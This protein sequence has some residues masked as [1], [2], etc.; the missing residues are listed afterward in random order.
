M[1]L[2]KRTFQ[3]DPQTRPSNIG[4]P[5]TGHF[6]ITV[7]TPRG[8]QPFQPGPNAFVTNGKAHPS[9]D[10]KPVKQE[11]NLEV[12][13]N[14]YDDKGK[15][16]AVSGDGKERQANGGGREGEASENAKLESASQASKKTFRCFTCGIDCTKLRFHY[17]KSTPATANANPNAGAPDSK[18]DLC[19]TCFLQGRLPA[20]HQASDF[21]KLEDS[22]YTRFPDRDAPWTDSELLLLLEG[23]ENFDDDWGQIAQHVG[24]RTAEECVMK[25]LQLE[26][27][28]KYLEDTTASLAG[29]SLEGGARNQ[30]QQPISQTENPVLS[31][32][33]HLAQ[34][35]QPSVAAAASG[36]TVAEVQRILR[37]Q[38]EG[39]TGGAKQNGKEGE[40]TEETAK[41]EQDAMEI[42]TSTSPQ[43]GAEKNKTGDDNA[44][45]DEQAMTTGGDGKPDGGA[46]SPAVVALAT[47]AGRAAVLAS[48]EE[49][50]MT[51]LV[52][53][54]VN[55]TLQ[56][57]ELKLAQFSEMEQLVEA[58]R[59][60]LE[61][62]RQQLVGE[63]LAVKKGARQVQDIMRRASQAPS[64][65]EAAA[66]A[67][68]ANLVGFGEG[69]GAVRRDDLAA[70]GGGSMQ[71]SAP[72]SA[73]QENGD[74]K[75]F[76]L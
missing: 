35:A 32:V 52:S 34:M 67:A 31:V 43:D 54:A 64:P 44:K 58:E 20:S 30:Q 74:F 14:I 76:E 49:R 39:R 9:T 10:L 26:I 63:R 6:R 62:A 18:Y 45:Q 15:K 73:A 47:S 72:P 71:S 25:F 12:R 27:E 19:P 46:S 8:L 55:T 4:P 16:I 48:H 13:R 21:V 69:F 22:P 37:N 68:E 59:R 17:T 1:V 7:D 57:L 36:R 61:I 40:R 29:S 24:T 23:L 33:A 70:G 60:D 65:E 66:I 3:V 51:R 38:I 41:E 28:D 42:D 50:E 53:S 5:F 11:M 2:T 56:K 75:N